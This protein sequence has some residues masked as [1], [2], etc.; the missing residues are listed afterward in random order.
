MAWLDDYRNT[1]TAIDSIYHRPEGPSKRSDAE[2]LVQGLLDMAPDKDAAVEQMS[3]ITIM[4]MVHNNTD[5]HVENLMVN[6]DFSDIQAIDHGYCFEPGLQSYKSKIHQGFN[7]TGRH[8]KI[9]ASVRERLEKTSYGDMRQAHGDHLQEWQIAQ[10]YMRMQYVMHI[11]DEND[12]NLPYDAFQGDPT[13]DRLVGNARF[14]DFMVDWIDTHSTDPDSPHHAAAKRFDQV[15]VFIDP[16]NVRAEPYMMMTRLGVGENYTYEQEVRSEK[17]AAEAYRNPGAPWVL[18]AKNK[19]DAKIDDLNAPKLKE[20]KAKQ[21]AAMKPYQDLQHEIMEFKRLNKDPNDEYWAMQEAIQPLAKKA[22]EARKEFVDLN[23]KT[24]N[25]KT[26]ER[27]M[28]NIVPEGY[29][30]KFDELEE[31]VKNVREDRRVGGGKGNAYR[32]EHGTRVKSPAEIE[33]EKRHGAPEGPT[34]WRA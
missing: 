21:D 12:G 23:T 13:R 9:P 1:M 30:E 18:A 25:Q 27:R 29:R 19:Q 6:E 22:K 8:L 14:E 17:A 33:K 15:G 3:R 11:A 16:A 10:T 24:E 2:N 26:L 20:A 28:F 34:G 31:K 7:A 32:M 5:R 4:D